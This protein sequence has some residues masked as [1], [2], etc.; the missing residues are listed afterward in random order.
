MNSSC[1][2]HLILASTSLPRQKLLQD[3]RFVF[4]VEASDYEEIMDPTLPP[5]ELAEKLALGK[6]QAVAHK[7]PNEKVIIIAADSFVIFKG[8]YLGKPQTPQ[9]A[10]EVLHKIQASQHEIITGYVVLDTRD[11][12]TFQGHDLV[13]VT[14]SP[15]SET[16]IARY[17]A[18]GEP[19][20]KAGGY[21]V[22]GIGQ[23][24]IEK[25]EGNLSTVIGLPI[26]KIYE[27]LRDLGMS[28][29]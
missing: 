1:K 18:T 20:S 15:M 21:A 6:A 22:Q 12:K 16:E 8:E 29:P 3:A 26:R 13:Q 24:F 19:L 4:A 10:R 9:K 7:H 2:P 25:I 23:C 28:I 27:I 5:N 17:V 11:G 14:M